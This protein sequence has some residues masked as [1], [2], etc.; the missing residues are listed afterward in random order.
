MFDPDAFSSD[1]EH[2]FVQPDPE[3]PPAEQQNDDA[4]P[5]IREGV[6]HLGRKPNH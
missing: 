6:V 5:W 2:P 3:D 4:G 1:F